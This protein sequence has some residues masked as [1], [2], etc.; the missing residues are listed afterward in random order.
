MIFFKT[1]LNSRAVSL[2]T[3]YC[4]PMQ[5][6]TCAASRPGNFRKLAVIAGALS[7]G[8]GFG[9]QNVSIISYPG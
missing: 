4:E 2:D 5:T 1:A 9:L 8:V 6:I 7:V 3:A